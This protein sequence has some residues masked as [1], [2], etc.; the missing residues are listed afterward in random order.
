MSPT[1]STGGCMVPRSG[2]IARHGIYD[3]RDVVA[4]VSGGASGI[5]AAVVE[6]MRAGGAS[7][8]IAD[9]HCTGPNKVDVSVADEVRE[10]ADYVVGTHGRCDTLVNCAGVIAVGTAVECA[11]DDWD[12]VQGVNVRGTWLMSKYLV[13]HMSEGS[14]IV[15][16]SS[17]AGLRA[18]PNMA[19]YVTAKHAVVGMTRAMAIDHAGQGLRVN[20]VCPGVVDTPLADIAQQLRPPEIRASVATHDER[21]IKRDGTV[22]EL[23]DSICFLASSS[24]SFITGATLA[25][26]G[27][28]TMH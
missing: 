6:Q 17:G 28:R 23:S 15:N 22:E 1:V 10:F 7:V 9:V 24:S 18:I 11:E 25:V 13:P 27:G 2:V 5:G 21:L 12:R 26:D 20:C 4:V 14:S 3:F 8:E 16:V 19:A